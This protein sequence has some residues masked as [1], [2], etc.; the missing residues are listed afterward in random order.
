MIE[1]PTSIVIQDSRFQGGIVLKLI[2]LLPIIALAAM[3]AG[4]GSS[5]S[6]NYDFDQSSDFASYRTFMWMAAPL[7]EA[8]NAKVAQQR[9]SLLE[10]RIKTATVNE[11]TGKGMGSVSSSPDLYVTYHIG[12]QDKVD[13]QSWGYGYGAGRYGGAYGGYGGGGGIDTYNYTEGTLII[14]L[15]D[16]S[17]EQLIWRGTATGVIDDNPSPEKLT[18]NINNVVARILANYPPS[19]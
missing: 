4:C 2:R 1:V 12:A 19:R 7:P 8:G 14:D 17:S 18:E 9:N 5:I 6:I 10:G 13:I 15:I 11:L 16:A 3:L